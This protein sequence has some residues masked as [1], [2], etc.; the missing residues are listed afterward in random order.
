[1]PRRP[2]TDRVAWI[3]KGAG[4]LKPPVLGKMVAM[5]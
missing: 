2:V 4:Y 3:L 5:I 1:M